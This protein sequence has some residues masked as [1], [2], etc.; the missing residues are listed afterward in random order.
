M[1]ALSG[2]LRSC[3][4]HEHARQQ[5]RSFWM[6][7]LNLP[8]Y[9]SVIQVACQLQKRQQSLYSPPECCA[10]AGSVCAKSAATS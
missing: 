3:R 8:G 2:L 5:N 7:D 10:G 1:P 9:Y 6:M 4:H